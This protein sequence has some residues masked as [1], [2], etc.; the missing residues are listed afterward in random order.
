MGFNESSHLHLPCS[1]WQMCLG[2]RYFS[3]VNLAV[4]VHSVEDASK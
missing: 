4:Q 3:I 2:F 1:S